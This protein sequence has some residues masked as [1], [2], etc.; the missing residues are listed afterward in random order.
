MKVSVDPL[1]LYTRKPPNETTSSVVQLATPPS[2]DSRC[3]SMYL[4]E[5][6]YLAISYSTILLV[7]LVVKYF[8]L[9]GSVH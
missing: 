6:R 9:L 1:K 8:R 7:V 5:A 3:F 4:A 2:V